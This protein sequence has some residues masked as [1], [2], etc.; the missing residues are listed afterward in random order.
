MKKTINEVL[1]FLIGFGLR[2]YYKKIKISGFEHIPKNKPLLI[3]PNHQNGLID[4]ILIGSLCKLN[5][6]YLARSDVF[7]NPIAN[8]FLRTIQML[9]IYRIRD[10][11]D[12]LQKNEAIFDCCAELLLQS[13]NL[14]L[15]PEGSHGIDRRVRI[16]KNGFYH[17]LSRS[18]KENPNL[19]VQILPIGLNYEHLEQYPDR[20]A[21]KIGKPIS[22]LNLIHNVDE[23]ERLNLLKETLKNE[24]IKLTTHIEDDKNYTE[25]FEY[26]NYKKANFL[27]PEVNNELI[28]SYQITSKRYAIEPNKKSIIS[29]LSRILLYTINLPIVLFWKLKVGYKNFELEFVSTFRYAVAAIGY[30]ILILLLGV[31]A[32]FFFPIKFVLV[33]ILGHYLIS[34]ILVK[35]I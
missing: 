9:P 17:I 26:L 7:K 28:A 21:I 31:V 13:K 16:L 15:F 24:L 1:R 32:S 35:A 2:S 27:T 19:D 29:K 6:Y 34:R 5:P 8:W 18:L 4:P 11:R 33:G 3:L 20:V 23:S 10:G 30:V 12:T 14:L 22:V 25:Y